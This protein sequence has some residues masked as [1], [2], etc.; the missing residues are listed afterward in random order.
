MGHNRGFTLIELLVVIAIIGILAAILLPALARAR[1]AARRSSCQNNLKQLGVIYKMYA[2]E[3]DGEQFPPCAPFGNPFMNGMT[4]FSAPDAAAVYPEYL[5]D[6]DV[7]KCPSDTG[8]DA[9]GQYVAARLPDSGDFDSWLAEAR[10]ANDRMSERYYLSA[11]LG[12][13]Y[14]YKGY[15][16][17]NREEY[18]GIWGGMGSLPFL[19]VVTILNITTPVRVKDFTQDIELTQDNWPTMVDFSIATGSAGSDRVYRLREGIERFFITDINNPGA[20]AMAQSTIAVSW[21]TFGNPANAAAT[22]GISVFNHVPGGC[23]VLY[24]DGH[25][26]FIR[27][28]D[29]FPVL[30]DTG[31]LTENGHFGLY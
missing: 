30:D 22:A 9:G 25:V 31:I 3:S 15:A 28:P 17:T 23:N 18:Y 10:A 20:S 1:E 26:D 19:Q 4:L 13:S 21:D 2:N 24:M 27:Y 12:R 8:S 7:A 29:R 6:L 14:L 11:Q 5:T 16:S